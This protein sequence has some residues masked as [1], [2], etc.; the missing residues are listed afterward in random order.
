[1]SRLLRRKIGASYWGLKNGAVSWLPLFICVGIVFTFGCFS[2]FTYG[3]W[4]LSFAF[5][6]S[7]NVLFLD[8]KPDIWQ[9]TVCTFYLLFHCKVT[10]NPI[11]LCS[12]FF[13]FRVTN[14][15]IPLCNWELRAYR[16]SSL[17][18]ANN[19]FVVRAIH[20]II[21]PIIEYV[22]QWH[23]LFLQLFTLPKRLF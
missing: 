2:L 21:Q 7:Y 23:Y 15:F 3:F 20:K 5:L 4:V 6:V 18:V 9:V 1:M 17:V 19:I 16:I 8:K 10:S 12:L 14:N 13:H 11:P 22:K